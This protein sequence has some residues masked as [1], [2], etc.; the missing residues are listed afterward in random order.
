MKTIIGQTGAFAQAS[1]RADT[2]LIVEVDV[3]GADGNYSIPSGFAKVTVLVTY[4]G[5]GTETATLQFP[6]SPQLGDEVHVI[7][8]N[9]PP[10]GVLKMNGSLGTFFVGGTLPIDVSNTKLVFVTNNRWAFA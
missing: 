3:G 10:A 7:P 5:N 8:V 1:S 9:N 4:N 6:G 2:S